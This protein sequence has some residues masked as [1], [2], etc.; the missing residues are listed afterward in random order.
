[1]SSNN[2]VYSL[3]G[4]LSAFCFPRD[5]AGL[6]ADKLLSFTAQRIRKLA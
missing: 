5:L 4:W 2:E 1:V 6:A 3:S